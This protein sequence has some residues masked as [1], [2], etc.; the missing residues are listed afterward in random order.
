MLN[1]LRE[2]KVVNSNAI[3]IVPGIFI[4]YGYIIAISGCLSSLTLASV[5][6]SQRAKEPVGG[7]AMA[8]GAA[9]GQKLTGWNIHLP[10]VLPSGILDVGLACPVGLGGRQMDAGCVDRL[11]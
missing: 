8:A 5:G 6:R 3:G 9:L 4:Q 7:P 1:E 2:G 11:S 10:L